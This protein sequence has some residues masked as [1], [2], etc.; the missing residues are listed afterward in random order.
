MAQH[1]IVISVKQCF[2]EAKLILVAV[3]RKLTNVAQIIHN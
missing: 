2:N 1:F 3:V